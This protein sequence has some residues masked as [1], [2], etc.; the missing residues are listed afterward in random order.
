MRRQVSALGAVALVRA[1]LEI[2]LG[3]YLIAVAV[4]WSGASWPSIHLDAKPVVGDREAFFAFGGVLIV[5]SLLRTAQAL[6]SLR[7]AEWGRRAGIVLAVFDLATW[8]VGFPFTLVIVLFAF[9]SLYVYR[10]PDTR[11]YFQAGA[12]NANAKGA[13]APSSP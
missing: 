10:H 6:A 7:A 11:G 12:R 4:H 9:W 8:W 1:V 3:G 5:L 2:L 13:R